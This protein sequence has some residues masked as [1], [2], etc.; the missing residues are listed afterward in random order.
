MWTN[1][2]KKIIDTCGQTDKKIIDTCAQTGKNFY[3]DKQ[4]KNY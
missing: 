1:R 3:V 4:A 2:Q